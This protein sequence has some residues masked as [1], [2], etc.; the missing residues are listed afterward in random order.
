MRSVVARQLR[1]PG[2]APVA[3]RLGEDV[4]ELDLRGLRHAHGYDLIAQ[5]ADQ[6]E[7]FEELIG[8]PVG[9]PA[10]VVR[11]VLPLGLAPEKVRQGSAGAIVVAEADG[12]F[13]KRQLAA[14]DLGLV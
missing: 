1:P 9:V 14:N 7:Q 10:D 4:L 13:G 8:G 3:E 2:Q 12:L 11:A 6:R 5:G